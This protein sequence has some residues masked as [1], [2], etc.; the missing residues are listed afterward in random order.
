MEPPISPSTDD[1]EASFSRLHNSGA[2]ILRIHNG[3]WREWRYD[4]WHNASYCIWLPK[5]RRHKKSFRG[6][7]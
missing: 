7:Y 1:M 6:D 2:G 4:T 5:W 3:G